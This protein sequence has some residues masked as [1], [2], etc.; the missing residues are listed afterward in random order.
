MTVLVV[1]STVPL[2][3]AFL[4]SEPLLHRMYPATFISFLFC[5]NN[6]LNAVR[7]ACLTSFLNARRLTDSSLT[8]IMYALYG[9]S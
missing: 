6:P 2:L 9:G 3:T 4:F 7:V 5:L 8:P 1:L